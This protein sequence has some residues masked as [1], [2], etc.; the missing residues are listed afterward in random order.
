MLETLTL[1][2]SAPT[3]FVSAFAMLFALTIGPNVQFWLERSDLGHPTGF[4]PSIDPEVEPDPT[5][6]GT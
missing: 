2:L 1:P 6:A 5:I 3:G 4:E